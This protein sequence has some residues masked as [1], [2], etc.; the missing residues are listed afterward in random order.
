MSA[1][2]HIAISLELGW[3]YKHHQDVFVGTQQYA[4]QCGFCDPK[5]MA[6]AFTRLVGLSPNAY[7]QQHKNPTACP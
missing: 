5:H 4:R 3:P 2:K 6:H 7:R 1:K